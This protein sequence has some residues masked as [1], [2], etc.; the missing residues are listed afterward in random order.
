MVPFMAHGSL[1]NNKC[2]AH[3]DK[4]MIHTL[5][6]TSQPG[7]VKVYGVEAGAGAVQHL[8]PR[9]LLHRQVNQ[10]WLV[11]QLWKKEC[12]YSVK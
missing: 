9:P 4:D 8:E 12:S 7:T 10:Q 11:L 1:Y 6:H 2:I 5:S 3:R